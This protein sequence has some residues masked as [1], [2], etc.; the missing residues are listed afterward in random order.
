MYKNGKV[1]DVVIKRKLVEVLEA[2]IAPIRTKRKHFEQRPDD[3]MDA[4]RQG[5]K[6]HANAVAGGDTIAAALAKKAMKQDYF[7]RSLTLG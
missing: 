6:R 5:T 4:L 7:S 3:V 2:V 1:G